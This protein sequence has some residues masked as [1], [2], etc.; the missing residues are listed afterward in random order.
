M[1]VNLKAEMARR[2]ITVRTLSELTEIPYSTLAPKIRGDYQIT[3]T[4]ADKIKAAI[5][6]DLPLE[7]L[8]KNE[9]VI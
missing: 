1:Y 9:E 5:G 7:T 3:L 4:E 6:T 8:F 2:K